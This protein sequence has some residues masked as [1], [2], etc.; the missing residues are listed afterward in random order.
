MR[1]YLASK[2][3]PNMKRGKSKALPFHELTYLLYGAGYLK[4][5]LSLSLSKNI[6]LSLCNPKVHYRVHKSPPLSPILSQPNP[7]HPIYPYPPKVRLNVILPPT[8]TS[9]QWSLTVGPPNQN[10][11]NTSP[12]L[13]E[14]HMSRPPHPPWFN[15]P[16]N[17]KWRS[18]SLCSFLHDPSS[19]VLGP[20]ILLNNLFSKTLSL[21]SSL[22]VRDQVSHPY[23][24]T[25]KI[26][27]LYILIFMFFDMR[28]EDR[29]FWTEW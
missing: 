14:C 13:N 26:T 3:L 8:S 28:R 15:H 10:P 11:V 17:I 27:V 5:W 24:T 4:S 2:L 12:L 22:K 25:G 7:V 21:C 20:N 29:R 19:S 1:L 23:R 6:L 9:S 18:S 16:N